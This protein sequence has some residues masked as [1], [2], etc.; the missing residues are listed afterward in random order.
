MIAAGMAEV[1][2]D[3]GGGAASSSGAEMDGSHKGAA[4]A[5][6]SAK[7][8]APIA[9]AKASSSTSMVVEEANDSEEDGE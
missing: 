2:K 5:K 3:T 7:G 4:R 1:K 6:S 9:G 8:K